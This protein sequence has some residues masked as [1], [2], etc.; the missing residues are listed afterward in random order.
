MRECNKRYGAGTVPSV[1]TFVSAIVTPS[2]TVA[3]A[4]RTHP[5]TFACAPTLAP[6]PTIEPRTEAPAPTAAPGW[7]TLSS[8]VAP[9]ATRA[10]APTVLRTPSAALGSTSAVGA[11][12]GAS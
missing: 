1:G 7:S 4:P 6:G 3:P 8:T 12:H 2:G 11:I 9:A 10:S 5:V